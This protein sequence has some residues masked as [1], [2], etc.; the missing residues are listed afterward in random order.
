MATKRGD[1]P[2]TIDT[3]GFAMDRSRGTAESRSLLE[4]QARL[5]ETQETLARADLRH[6]GWQII[7]E[8]VGA[9]I[10][11]LTALAACLI[12]LG[13]GAF[14]W[15]A[16][17]AS[18]MVVDTFA[19]P[20]AMER[21]GL[22]GAVVAGQ[23]LD[24]VTA[25]EASTE[26]ARAP[27][28]Y[29]NSWSDTGGVVVPYTGVSLGQLRRDA[30]EWLGS[31]T[32]LKGEVVQLGGGRI[33]IVFRAGK[34]SG[35]VEGNEAEFDQVL[36]QAAAAVFKATQP[37]RYVVWL[38]RNGG[39][40]AE[41]YEVLTA[42]SRSSDQRD[43]LWALHGL[44]L[45]ANTGTEAQAI[46]R[47]ALRLRSDF[48]PAIGNLPN[49]ALEAGREEEA[50]KLRQRAAAAYRAGQPDY[51]PVH[52][53][54]YAKDAEATL[55][56]MKGD[57]QSA[58]R[59]RAEAVDQVAAANIV[60]VR[61]FAA[62]LAQANIHDFAGA[63]A[64]LAA[65][66]YLDPARRADVETKYGRQVSLEELH[67]IATGDYGAQARLLQFALMAVQEG[68]SGASAFSS[69]RAAEEALGQLRPELAVVLARS[70]N[71]RAAQAVVAPLPADYDAAIRARGLIA[72][73]AGRGPQSDALFARAVA[74]TPSLPAGH[75]AWAEALM[76]RGD[77]KR[78]IEQ[79]A[80]AHR[81]GSR[82]AEPLKLWGDALLAHGN[83]QEAVAKYA[84]AA[85]QAPRWGRLQMNWAAALWRSGR[86]ED[87]RAKLRA[88]A[89]MDLSD[90]DRRRLR[91]MWEKAQARP[92]RPS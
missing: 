55:A 87:A 33:G 63:R 70:G 45:N 76:V 4:W 88:A 15:S 62:A 73:Y 29:E 67:A 51:N 30:R 36:K 6:R 38:G 53:T 86:Q 80:L 48:L 28:S 17:R 35:R 41:A 61:P 10:K 40:P 69:Q 24:H 46:Y 5:V 58:A 27:S 79:A 12:L 9:L 42:L 2:D 37:Y 32:H 77:T 90:A 83:S 84:E 59:M 18:G 50:Y 43:R 16:S 26:S 44:A 82:W 64:A 39:N 52:A 25:M 78:A 3:I 91:F 54:S 31:E 66:G 71:W 85:E 8:R 49:Y 65:A 14:L 22:S 92:D 89:S 21:Q 13:L 47:R 56:E 34:S 68:R 74:R 81:A 60:A 11:G 23:L 57:L 1:Q 7:G 20:P 75:H 19:V 72:A